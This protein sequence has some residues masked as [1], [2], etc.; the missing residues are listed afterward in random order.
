MALYTNYF[1]NASGQITVN[2]GTEGGGGSS[3]VQTINTDGSVDLTFSPVLTTI[4]AAGD[5]VSVEG[6]DGM[7]YTGV[8][9]GNPTPMAGSVSVMLVD[10]TGLSATDSVTTSFTSGGTTVVEGHQHV[11]GDVD[12]QG[13]LETTGGLDVMG[14]TTNIT[15]NNITIGETRTD[16]TETITT[17]NGEVRFGEIMDGPGDILVAIDEDNN[18]EIVSLNIGTGLSVSSNTL[19]VDALNL[20]ATFFYTTDT[21]PTSS[22]NYD[23]IVDELVTAF[24]AATASAEGGSVTDGIRVAGGTSYSRGDL[25]L[26]SADHSNSPVVE[27]FIYIGGSVTAP[28]DIAGADAAARRSNFVDITF[29]GDVVRSLSG[30]AGQI[31]SSAATGNVE[32]SF[33]NTVRFPE[34]IVVNRNATVTGNL[35]VNGTTLDVNAN[36]DVD[37]STFALDTTDTS[38]SSIDLNS[39]GGIDI[40]A[41]GAISIN[42]TPGSGGDVVITSGGTGD[43]TIIAGTGQVEVSGAG[44]VN[45]A[46][47]T[48]SLGVNTSGE[49]VTQT[50]TV[51]TYNTTV[52][53]GGISGAS[54]IDGSI[55]ILGGIPASTSA[56]NRTLELPTSGLVAGHSIK[57]VNISST[58]SSTGTQR[59]LLEPST[60][61]IMG[62]TVSGVFTL[63][64]PTASFELV[65]TNSTTGWAIIGAN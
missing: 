58:A 35:T 13:E 64:D 25:I 20:N 17:L 22:S 49:V 21:A 53:G 10:N 19:S 34:D 4:P 30:T 46:S 38:A 37:G 54:L 36:V 31:I 47:G 44:I 61:P 39:G 48:R 15:T 18:N 56:A 6:A 41:H 63:D 28:S 33:P 43:V 2:E 59:Y 45:P 7:T 3:T 16:S 60:I 62:E 32:L 42:T 8:V 9:L 52:S 1:P 27:S 50:S 26:I 14:D 5:F 23:N 11:G 29:T 24:N 65:Y 40:D 51:H 55:V 57:I 12:I